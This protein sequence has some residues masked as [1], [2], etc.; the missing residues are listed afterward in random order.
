MAPAQ[1]SKQGVAAVRKALRY[2]PKDAAHE[3]IGSAFGPQC[4][5]GCRLELASEDAALLA[6]DLVGLQRSG[7]L[8]GHDA[9]I[10]R[11]VAQLSTMR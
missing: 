4:D 3:R 8:L 2:L 10:V 9:A 1:I 5:E 11:V 7:Q 6:K